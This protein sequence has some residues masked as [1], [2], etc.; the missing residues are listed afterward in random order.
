MKKL[1]ILTQ[2][3][4][5]VTLII[6]ILTA[7]GKNKDVTPTS[8]DNTKNLENETENISS[9]EEVI[10]AETNEMK[11]K[12]E[13]LSARYPDQEPIPITYIPR[14]GL[15]FPFQFCDTVKEVE[16]L[17]SDPFSDDYVDACIHFENKEN[18]LYIRDENYQGE[19]KILN[20][21]E[22]DQCSLDTNMRYPQYMPIP[23]AGTTGYY[24]KNWEIT[25]VIDTSISYDGKHYYEIENEYNLKNLV[26]VPVENIPDFKLYQIG[27]YDE[28]SYN[29]PT[30]NIR[31]SHK[32]FDIKETKEDTTEGFSDSPCSV[33]YERLRFNTD[34]YS[35]SIVLETQELSEEV[36]EEN[37]IQHVPVNYVADGE[38]ELLGH[39]YQRYIYTYSDDDFGTELIWYR[40]EDNKIYSISSSLPYEKT[41]EYLEP[42]STN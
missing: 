34:T 42:Y 9:Q 39:L 19:C 3:I 29:N 1:S 7:C 10:D 32:D 23:D 30:Y 8:V 5:T 35:V 36:T 31:V 16:I 4:L 28:S 12:Y 14:N 40:Y 6:F 27:S 21:D 11:S 24:T 18:D 22:I 20:Y 37:F 17:G 33:I 25:N 38:E 41:F 15:A 26:A 13:E 2:L